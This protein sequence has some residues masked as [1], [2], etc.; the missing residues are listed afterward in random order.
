MKKKLEEVEKAKALAEEAR[1]EAVKTKD[2][3]EQHGY[4]VGVV[5]TKDSLRAEVPTVC[6]TY[7]DLVWDVALNQARVEAFS[8]LRKAESR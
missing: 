5:E 8:V 2:A 4:D 7:C 3:A 1:D 6:R